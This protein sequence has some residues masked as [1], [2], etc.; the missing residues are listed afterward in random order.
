MR[1][2]STPP[3]P[4][5]GFTS[6]RSRPMPLITA[7]A[8]EPVTLLE[9]KL[10]LRVDHADDDTLITSLI[11]TA[12]QQAEHR[13][14]R[15]YGVQTWERAYDAFPAWA[16]LLPDP[17]VT[18]IVSIKYDNAN[19]IEQTLDP[20]AYRLRPHSEPAAVMPVSAGRQRWPSRARCVSAISAGCPARTPAGKASRPGCCWPWAPGMPIVKPPEPCK[21]TICPVIFGTACLTRCAFMAA[22][23]GN[24]YG[25]HRV[26]WR[27]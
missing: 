8:V 17:P 27:A 7:P 23:R 10:H 3:R 4:V 16:L 24:R 21:T 5:P 25:L 14:G 9:A 2:T 19:A 13:T 20:A 26:R 6:A 22:T 11:K 1:G 15:R 18:A 12:R